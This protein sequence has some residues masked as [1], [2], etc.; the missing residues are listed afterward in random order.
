MKKEFI[1]KTAYQRAHQA[2]FSEYE[3]ARRK[4]RSRP[5]AKVPGLPPPPANPSEISAALDAYGRRQF[6]AII[7]VHRST[8]ARWECGASVMPRSAWLLLVLLNEGRL[9]GMSEDWRD[10]RF[11]GDRLHLVGSRLSYSA[12]EIAGWPYQMAHA[13]ALA[14]EIE[15]LKK[16]TA[17]LLRVGRFDCDNDASI[18]A[19]GRLP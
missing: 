17:Y 10:F 1:E 9:P 5:C 19:A 2:W 7:G 14:S 18:L 16:Q 8:L 12:R 13:A 4:T 6:M 11:D 15:R 3:R